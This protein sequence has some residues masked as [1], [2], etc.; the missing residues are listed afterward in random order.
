[1]RKWAT[2][3]I[4][5]MASLCLLAPAPA[6]ATSGRGDAVS[7]WLE[8]EEAATT[9]LN[10]TYPY[11]D[12][13][14]DGTNDYVL[15]VGQLA[16]NYVFSYEQPSETYEPSEGVVT[17]S[18]TTEKSKSYFYRVSHPSGDDAVTYGNY[19]S[20]SAD[21]DVAVTT[22][23]LH[24]GDA[25]DKGTVTRDFSGN[26]YDAGDLYLNV[27][28]TG[29]LQLQPGE[30]FSLYP[31][32]NWLPV[33]STMNDR[34]LQPDFHVEAIDVEGNGVVTTE[35]VTAD[36]A[37]KHKWVLTGGNEGT[38]LVKVTYNALTHGAAMGGSDL[39]AIWPENTGLFV[40]TVGGSHDVKTGLT[41]DADLN[42]SLEGGADKLAGDAYDSELDV[43]YFFNDAGASIT[44]T[45]ETGAT[46]RVARGAVKDGALEVSAFTSEGVSTGK[47]GSV[48]VGGIPE[49][50]SIIEVEKNGATSYQVVRARRATWVAYGGDKADA[51]H[52]IATSAGGAANAYTN[53]SEAITV[54]AY[55]A[56][57][58]NEQAAFEPL[59]TPGGTMT[60]VFDTVYHPANKLSG[61]YNMNALLTLEDGDGNLTEAKLA[62]PY[63][64][65]AQYKF[66]QTASCQ[67]LTVTLPEWLPETYTLTMA[68]KATGYGSSYGAHRAIT[69]ENGAPANSNATLQ[70]AYLCSSE[71]ISISLAG[72]AST[73]PK[74]QGILPLDGKGTVS[75][76]YLVRTADDYV[77]VR[78]TVN[79]GESLEG[80]HLKQAADIE[81]PADWTPIGVLKDESIRSIKS[82]E[83]LNAFSG[84]LDGGGH[85]LIVPKGG[86][87]LLGY[88]RGAEVRNLCIF[89]EQI[90]GAGLVNNLE[91]RGLSGTSLVLDGITLKSG[92][93]TLRSGLV[94]S[95]LIESPMAACPYNYLASISNCTIEEGV[96]VGYDGTCSEI[97]GII[98][99]LQGTM[100]NCTCAAMVLGDGFVGGLIGMRDNAMGTVTVSGSTFSGEL[101]ATGEHAGGIA[102]G[103]YDNATAPNAM[104]IGITG[105][106]VT[107]TVSGAD[108]V[109]G[110]L[111]GDSFT[112]QAW[113]GYS[114]ANN[115]F[116]GTVSA[117]AEGARCIG[118]VIG[119]YKSLNK[120]DT[121]TNNY[122]A[123]GCGAERG[124]G[125]VQYVD[126]SCATHETASGAIYFNTA[127][128]T[129]DCPKVAGCAWKKGHNR[130]DDPL[131]TGA[132]ALCWTDGAGD[133]CVSIE[134]SGDYKTEYLLGEALSTEGMTV[135]GTWAEG[136]TKGVDPASCAFSG[137]DP[138]T[139]GN[140]V[141]A[142]SYG[143][144]S[145]TYVVSVTRD[146]GRDWNTDAEGTVY[147][148]VSNEAHFAVSDGELSGMTMAYVPIRLA[149]VAAWASSDQYAGLGLGD[150]RVWA[151]SWADY[152]YDL[153]VLQLFTYAAETYSS[154]GASSVEFS[155]GPGAVYVAGGFFG[156]TDNL[157]YYVNGAFPMKADGTQGA[158]C[159][160]LVLADGMFVDV[161]L[162]S[163]R[164]FHTDSAA[165]FHYFM[166]AGGLV[167]HG[168]EAVEGVPCTISLARIYDNTDGNYAPEA[169]WTVHWG[170]AADWASYESDAPT[171]R[172]TVKTGADGRAKLTFPAAGTYYLW[173]DGGRGSAEAT[174][175]AIVSTP[176]YAKVTVAAR[177][178]ISGA[179]MTL[180]ASSATYNGKGQAP[181]VTS[182]KLGG[183]KLT[184]GTDY[185]VSYLDSKK[186]AVAAK[187][188][189]DA[190]T[191][192][193]KVTGAGAYKGSATSKAFKIN[194][195]AGKLA[196]T[197]KASTV[198]KALV[199]KSAMK[200]TFEASKYRKVTKNLS[201]GTISY[202]LA[203]ITGP[204]SKATK[205]AK[206]LVTVST[207][208]GKITVKKGLPKGTYTLKVQMTS[209]ATKNYKSATTT[210]TVKLK[211]T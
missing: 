159:D 83:N 150:Y 174:A 141:V 201:G 182:V 149:D 131:G 47:D 54:D 51:A 43:L 144:A 158:S 163:D 75:K 7:V 103:V 129:D 10:V 184:A 29:H 81:L 53:G 126:T 94:N 177:K 162:F 31:L 30:E 118:G 74:P 132:S 78:D 120:L 203:T 164:G 65:P 143:K 191:Y 37:G 140:Q 206:K 50:K 171:E 18:F 181:S 3:A 23:D 26:A 80:V 209:A 93:R 173:V 84:V 91:G 24:V 82:G 170:T 109:G 89:G 22:N 21:K 70:T 69:Y 195:A 145:A 148:S 152:N 90:D 134:L 188:V 4:A 187:N 179:T 135:T 111:G 124:I 100:S 27:G 9:S 169:G 127:S 154:G 42:A 147:L 66:A 139:L 76:P 168:Y 36:G 189:K 12:E 156:G 157:N 115:R 61:V 59:A 204:S 98:G 199:A 35:E 67:T 172:G 62:N 28:P 63:G 33:A 202:K 15:E 113:N 45:P 40:V 161:A 58:A 41:I 198:K 114:F 64:G 102:G 95:D 105:C 8:T 136:T 46:V 200:A 137:Y 44:L 73:D 211:M 142:V 86:K 68:V 57:S 56:L 185:T 106:T 175:D 38:A 55:E 48:T 117:T 155:G 20:M 146:A 72:L 77:V 71:P 128:G 87:P 138:W 60:V 197:A 130:T 88:V 125:S 180:S 79:A 165:G 32:R 13:N 104:R 183:K 17:A 5:L 16:S 151:P 166:D 116:T 208:T 19:V 25:R 123:E 176:A 207:K 2:K 122:Y 167:T 121:L 186:K 153:T 11:A 34:L 85:T 110:I 196:V 178:D 97:G 210:I 160:E 101:R 205:S 194:K 1:M 112:A 39:S 49:G 6:L 119:F 107:G 96:T 108:K 190:G 14:D 92:S 133:R 193:V 192:Y 99:R 52:L